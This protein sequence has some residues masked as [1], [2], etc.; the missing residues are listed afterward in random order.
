MSATFYLIGPYQRIIHT[1]VNT[2][3]ISRRGI[4]EKGKQPIVPQSE[5]TFT[6]CHLNFELKSTIRIKTIA[7]IAP[8]K[9]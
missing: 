4:R 2:H 9:S 7:I 8:L 6:R 5:V 1:S 3:P